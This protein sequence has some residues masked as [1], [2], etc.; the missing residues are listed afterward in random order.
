MEYAMTR[1]S[2]LFSIFGMICSL[3]VLAG[4]ARADRC[5]DYARDAYDSALRECRTGGGN[6]CTRDSDCSAGRECVAGRC[7]DRQVSCVPNCAAR[8]SSGSC[9]SYNSDYCAVDA[10]CTAQCAAR[11]SSGDCYSYSS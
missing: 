5:D 4:T 8:S 10:E 1:L 3:G 2:R 6:E 11:S 9:Y 7:E